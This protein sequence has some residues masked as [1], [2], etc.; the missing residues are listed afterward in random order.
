MKLRRIARDHLASLEELIL[1]EAN[2]IFVTSRESEEATVGTHGKFGTLFLQLPSKYSRG[3]I[4][5]SHSGE[6]R[7]FDFSIKSQAGIFAIASFVDCERNI[8]VMHLGRRLCLK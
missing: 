6:K 4:V 1:D 3:E 7:K 2:G 5:L 8:M